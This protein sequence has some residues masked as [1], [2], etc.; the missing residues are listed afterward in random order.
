MA[1]E[2]GYTEGCAGG[3]AVMLGKRAQEHTKLCRQRMEERLMH[4]REN[5]ANVVQAWHEDGNV[6]RNVV[7]QAEAVR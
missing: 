7:G 2:G 4:S 3:K 5:N 6:D 1:A